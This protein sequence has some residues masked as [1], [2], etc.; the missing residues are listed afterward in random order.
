MTASCELILL[1]RALDSGLADAVA[2]IDEVEAALQD[3]IAPMLLLSAA[4]LRG[5]KALALAA[6]RG[7][8]YDAQ[9][10]LEQDGFVAT[11]THADHWAAAEQLLARRR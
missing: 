4:A 5:F 7:L 11:W 9:R 3:F 2:P 8:P 10:A 1:A 6:R